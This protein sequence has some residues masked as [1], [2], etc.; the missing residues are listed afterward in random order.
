LEHNMT[1]AAP[2][3]VEAFAGKNGFD[4]LVA[5]YR[6]PNGRI[7]A[8]VYWLWCAILALFPIGTLPTLGSPRSPS[9]APV[10]VVLLVSGLVI[11]LAALLAVLAV[12][13]VTRRAFYLYPQGYLLTGAF[14]L[15]VRSATWAEVSIVEV[16]P[17]ELR[18]RFLFWTAAPR[19]VCLIRHRKGRPVRFTEPTETAAL[20][21]DLL[22]L[23]AEA[24]HADKNPV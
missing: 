11:A 23:H 21:P 7:Y 2:A 3:R 13:S 10:G 16:Q 15:I 20:I 18:M 17:H 22:R 14:G 24:R 12:R 8:S 4:P 1:M 6:H 5:R 19:A 9:A